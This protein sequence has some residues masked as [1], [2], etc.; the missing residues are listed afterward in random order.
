M[1]QDSKSISTGNNFLSGHA[2]KVVGYSSYIHCPCAK[3]V[4]LS[5]EQAVLWEGESHR[6]LAVDSSRAEN[7]KAGTLHATLCFVFNVREVNVA[8]VRSWFQDASWTALS[9]L[10]VE[11]VEF[12]MIF[13]LRGTTKNTNIFKLHT[14]QP[15]LTL[16]SSY[17]Q[18]CLQSHVL[19]ATYARSDSRNMVTKCSIWVSSIEKQSFTELQN[20][21]TFGDRRYQ[22]RRT[23]RNRSIWQ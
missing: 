4:W 8:K 3:Q 2:I 12:A 5:V 15:L 16:P 17:S 20:V 23:D 22:I 19:C 10:A 21:L 13:T 14:D 11:F 9:W 6:L 1:A 7:V 18:T